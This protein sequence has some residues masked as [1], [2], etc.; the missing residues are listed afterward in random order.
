MLPEQAY[1][2]GADGYYYLDAGKEWV[3]T[4]RFAGSWL[5]GSAPAIDRLERA[6][7]HYFQRPDAEHVELHPGATSLQGYTGSVNLNRQK[8]NVIVNAA[9]WGTSPGFESNDLGFQTGGDI[10][11]AQAVVYWRKPNPDGLTRSRH[12]MA[13][14]WWTWDFA[15]QRQTDGYYGQ[16]GFTAMNYW[17]FWVEGGGGRRT[18]DDRLTRG[19]PAAARPANGFAF[20]GMDSDS[21]KKVSFGTFMGYE[22]SD[23]G[24]WDAS[25]NL[26]VSFKPF[27]SLT[28]SIRPGISRSRSTAQYVTTV[29]DA[30][31]V[32]TYGSRYVFAD[33]DQFQTSMTTRVNWILS[34]KMSLQVYMQPLISVGDYWGFKEFARPKTYSFLRYGQ[35]I[36]R[37]SSDQAGLYTADPDGDGPAPPFSFENPDF[38][39]KSLRI[40]AIF[41]W[42]W[43]LGSTLYFVWTQNRQ[44]FSNPGQFSPG[45]DISDLFSAP[46]D[47]VFLIRLAYWI[48]R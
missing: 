19:G 32:N 34:P 15:G 9:L 42:E 20:A 48:G 37:I 35:D 1:V 11:G 24:G 12:L 40:N 44:D 31:A 18:L 21:R 26:S 43:R 27:S 4:G 6:P 33:M 17:S 10:A 16:A 22:W 3:V 7:Q 23:A 13:A 8:G 5:T 30:T 47:D 41:R 36:G 14:K 29:T 38:N 28:L 39:F 45:R 25:G 2:A 46:A